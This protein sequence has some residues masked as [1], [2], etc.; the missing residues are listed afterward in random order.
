MKSPNPHFSRPVLP[1]RAGGLSQVLVALWAGL[2]AVFLGACTADVDPSSTGGYQLPGSSDIDPQGE[3]NFFVSPRGRFLLYESRRSDPFAPRFIVYDLTAQEPRRIELDPEAQ[4][5]SSEGRGPR[6]ASCRWARDETLVI[7]AG[8]SHFFLAKLDQ[9]SPRF[10]ALRSLDGV[11]ADFGSP[12][13]RAPTRIV[14][15]KSGDREVRLVDRQTSEVL[16]RH[17]ADEPGV[18]R[19]EIRHPALAPGER[20]LAYTVATYRTTFAGPSQAFILDLDRSRDGEPVR[21]ATPVFGP[22]RWHPEQ[23]TFFACVRNRKGETL[24]IFRWDLPLP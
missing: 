11:E 4:R 12:E 6:L 5:L 19:I 7:L 15:K 8:D 3:N 18:T 23:A 21:V 16:A 9:R 2:L 17:T 20:Y 14:I 10:R 24:G 22:V 13:L 1:L